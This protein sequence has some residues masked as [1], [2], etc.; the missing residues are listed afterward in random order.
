MLIGDSTLDEGLPDPRDSIL[1]TDAFLGNG[2]GYVESGPF[3][4][5][6][7][8]KKIQDEQRLFRTVGRA[9]FG[10]L[11]RN[12]DVAAILNKTKFEQLTAC[13][14][15]FFE[16]V[17][18]QTC[19]KTFLLYF[20]KRFQLHGTVHMWVGGYMLDI[21]ISPNDPSFYLHHAF[22]DY[23]WEQFRLQ[24]QDRINRQTDYPSEDKCC[25]LNHY[26][27]N[28][29]LPF[30]VPLSVQSLY[31]PDRNFKIIFR[32]VLLFCS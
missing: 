16:L 31:R 4:R 30:K 13:V 14:D 20:F 29:M 23:L 2:D 21:P 27:G 17:Y 32:L 18:M 12:D 8:T 15:P 5:W 24:K 26:M 9:P 7:T 6:N 19:T 22:V 25:N 11:Y 28:F 10:G 3:R 1:W